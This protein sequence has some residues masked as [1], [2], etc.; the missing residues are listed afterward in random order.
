[1]TPF[2]TRNH[3]NQKTACA[4][5]VRVKPHVC[6]QVCKVP[7]LSQQHRHG[8]HRIQVH[9]NQYPQVR[10]FIPVPCPTL[11]NTVPTQITPDETQRVATKHVCHQ[12]PLGDEVCNGSISVECPPT[13]DACSQS[14]TK[15]DNAHQRHTRSVKSSSRAE[16]DFFS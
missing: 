5:S 15:R 9:T 13:V 2:F 14:A 11:P 3:S 16:G 6:C 1:M 8:S 12:H 7:S 4:L 10:A